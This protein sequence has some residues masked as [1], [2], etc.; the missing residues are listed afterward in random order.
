[1]RLTGLASTFMGNGMSLSRGAKTSVQRKSI[2][3]GG[4][5]KRDSYVLAPPIRPGDVLRD[6]ILSDPEITQELLA[7]AMQVS[8]FSINQIVNGK[9]AVT[10]EM[11]LKL[12]RVLSTTPKLWLD[13]QRGVD[14]YAARQKLGEGID[15]LKVLRSPKVEKDLFIDKD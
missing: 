1:M 14:L 9:R 8:R 12:A 15:A 11:S 4:K 13:L 2:S 10:A 3:K 6:F 7:K 5:G